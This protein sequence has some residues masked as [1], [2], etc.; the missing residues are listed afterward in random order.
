MIYTSITQ[1]YTVFPLRREL[2]VTR[3]AIYGGQ[4]F[5]SHKW[6]TVLVD[7]VKRKPRN[8]EAYRVFYFYSIFLPICIL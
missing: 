3:S 5:D 4:K 2:H 6:P 1:N 7:E 8:F